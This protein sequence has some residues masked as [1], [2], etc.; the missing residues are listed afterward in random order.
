MKNLQLIVAPKQLTSYKHKGK[1]PFEKK[2]NICLPFFTMDYWSNLKIN[3]GNEILLIGNAK[4]PPF[5]FS[6]YHSL[7]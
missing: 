1:I 3:D 6:F 5:F 7:P 2:D 4:F